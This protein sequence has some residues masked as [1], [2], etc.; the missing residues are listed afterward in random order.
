MM[1]LIEIVDLNTAALYVISN[2]HEEDI[3]YIKNQKIENLNDIM[4]EFHHGFGTQVRNT[5]NLWSLDTPVVKWFGETYDLQH[6]DD[7]SSIIILQAFR[8]IIRSQD[9]PMEPLDN[10]WIQ[11]VVNR[12]HRHWLAAGLQRNGL[13]IENA[14][15]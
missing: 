4:A 9:F 2:M 15:N 1:E 5:L 8:L 12:Y 11:D 13:P 3:N 7:I 10:G 14:P 6:A